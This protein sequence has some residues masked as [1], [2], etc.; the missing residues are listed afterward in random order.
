MNFRILICVALFVL[1]PGCAKKNPPGMALDEIPA[2]VTAAFEKANSEVRMQAEMI[3]GS[4]RAKQLMLHPKLTA[5]Q[6]LVL[7]RAQITIGAMMREVAGDALPD[8]PTVK[9]RRG[10]AANEAPAGA[11]PPSEE[12][13]AQAAAT[14]RYYQR[15]K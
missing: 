1:L 4:V 9:V 7:A 13:A 15:S 14:V 8:A 5:E 11:E 2:A 3:V 10:A 6:R 12:Q